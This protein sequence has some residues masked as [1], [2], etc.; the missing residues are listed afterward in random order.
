MSKNL[1]N[2]TAGTAVAPQGEQKERKEPR[3]LIY[4][5]LLEIDGIQ[6]RRFS[7]LSDEALQIAIEGI[8]RHLLA[9]RRMDVNPDLSACR[10]LIDDAL[11]GKRIFAMEV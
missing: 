3:K 2:N 9:C 1:N 11:N 4:E 8:A 5:K 6:A 7:K 10:E